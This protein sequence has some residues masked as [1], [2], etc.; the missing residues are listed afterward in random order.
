M[1]GV[2]RREL[3]DYLIVFNEAQLRRLVR[4]YLRYYHVDR[5]HDGMG[6]DTPAKR[7]A[8]RREAG[9]GRLAALPRVGGLHHWYTWRVAA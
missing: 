1:G 3:L 9:H 2:C 6:K 4:E 5:T 8:E 7:P